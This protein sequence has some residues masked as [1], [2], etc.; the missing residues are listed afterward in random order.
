MIWQSSRLNDSGEII[1]NVN[2]VSSYNAIKVAAELGI[3]RVVQA[4]SVNVI[5]LGTFSWSCQLQSPTCPSL[6]PST[7]P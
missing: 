3:T 5:G 2:V 7:D 4:S 6:L 1:H